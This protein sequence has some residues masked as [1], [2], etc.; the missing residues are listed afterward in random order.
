MRARHYDIILLPPFLEDE[1]ATKP[2][3]GTYPFH[4]SDEPKLGMKENEPQNDGR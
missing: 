3:Q 1:G 4:Y 2:G